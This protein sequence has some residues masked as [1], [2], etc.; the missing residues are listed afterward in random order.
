VQ[1][2]YRQ[3]NQPRNEA[4]EKVTEPVHAQNVYWGARGNERG[5]QRCSV[6]PVCIPAPTG[7]LSAAATGMKN[8]K[9]LDLL[10][11]T[12]G[13][14]PPLHPIDRRLAKEWIKR[15]LIAVFPDLRRDPKA[16]EQA[17]QDLSL[18]LTDHDQPQFEG[19]TFEMK[20]GDRL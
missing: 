16:L 3:Q 2:H 17:Y 9:F 1:A 13:S 19:K 5:K 7:S 10:K 15:R 4:E 18:E 6:A 8:S 14:E 11:R 20:L 12:F